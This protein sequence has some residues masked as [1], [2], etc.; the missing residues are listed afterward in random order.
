MRLRQ[1]DTRDNKK[2][3]HG[4]HWQETLSDRKKQTEIQPAKKLNKVSN[5]IFTFSIATQADNREKDVDSSIH[6]FTSRRDP[7][8]ICRVTR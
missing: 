5:S 1:L 6:H 2:L 7:I 8:P 4:G 3:L